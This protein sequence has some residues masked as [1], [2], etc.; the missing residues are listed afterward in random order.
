[1]YQ[2]QTIN[3][4]ASNNSMLAQDYI[5]QKVIVYLNLNLFL[6]SP[7]ETEIFL[8]SF[9][10]KSYWNLKITKLCSFVDIVINLRVQYPKAR[11]SDA[12]TLLRPRRGF[13]D[14]IASVMHLRV[15]CDK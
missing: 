13:K 3:N 15:K 8:L 9:K 10:C 1:M 11:C 6:L 7:G 14:V 4:N 5:Y 2:Y 12:T